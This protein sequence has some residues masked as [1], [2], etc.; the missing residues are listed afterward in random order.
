MLLLVADVATGGLRVEGMQSKEESGNVYDEIVV[1]EA[2][3]RREIRIVVGADGDGAMRLV[4]EVA[5]RRGISFLPLPPYLPHL[6][7]VEFAVRH[8]KECVYSV[9][10]PAIKKD[11]PVTAKHCLFAAKFVCYTLE[12]LPKERI[13]KSY[14]GEYSVFV[15]PWKLNIG[16]QAKMSRLVPF[17]TAGYAFTDE[18]L[19]KARG[20]PKYLLAE[21]VIIMGYQHMYMHTETYECL[22]RHSSVRLF[23]YSEQSRRS[24]LSSLPAVGGKGQ[25]GPSGGTAAFRGSPA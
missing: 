1:N 15:S 23:Y 13:F 4:K 3:H 8:F 24:R 5:R 19:R 2:L 11:G 6:G 12:Q 16:T 10:L 18:Q 22:T 21:P 25:T 14:I 20:A 17:G 9:L 7:R